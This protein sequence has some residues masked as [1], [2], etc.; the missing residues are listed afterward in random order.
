[1]DWNR[2]DGAGERVAMAI[3][4]L[5]ARVPVTDKRYGGAILLNPGSRCY[6]T[7]RYIEIQDHAKKALQADQEAQALSSHCNAL[8][9]SNLL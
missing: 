6:V 1:M 7:V 8:N 4:K 5:P 2:T 3:V 9:K